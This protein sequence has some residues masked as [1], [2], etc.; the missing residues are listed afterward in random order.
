MVAVQGQTIK[1]DPLYAALR[2][3]RAGDG[4][5]IDGVKSPST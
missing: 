5:S 1:P 2:Y 4:S 3:G